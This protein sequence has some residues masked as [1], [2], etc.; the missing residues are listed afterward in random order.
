[1]SDPFAVLL[2]AGKNDTLEGIVRRLALN[3]RPSLE[4]MY[5]LLAYHREDGVKE[6]FDE[7]Y[8]A[9]SADAIIAAAEAKNGAG[10]ITEAVA[11]LT[12]K[13]GDISALSEKLDALSGRMAALATQ[14]SGVQAPDM[15][16]LAR[17]LEAMP[18]RLA[19]AIPPH[20]EMPE[21]NIPAHSVTVDQSE[22]LR[23]VMTLT[24]EIREMKAITKAPRHVVTD[25]NGN[26]T[27]VRIDA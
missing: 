13:V 17:E 16:A 10:Q 5:A 3:A 6:R 7:L 4:S 11:E 20:P 9:G 27:G 19:A 14:I 24:N 22:L 18:A 23:A 15:S 12:Q 1:M 8:G 21:I 26:V 25:M 2:A